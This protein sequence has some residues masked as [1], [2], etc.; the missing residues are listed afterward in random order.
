MRASC[1]LSLLASASLGCDRLIN[2]CLTA[3]QD[4]LDPRRLGIQ[5][6]G[7][8]DEDIADIICILLPYSEAARAELRE[9][10]LLN[11]KHMVET[12]AAHPNLQAP[13]GISHMPH[14]VGEHCIVLRLSAQYKDP[15]LGFAFGRNP[16]KCDVYFANDPFRRLS[17]IHFRIYLNE[18]GVLMLEDL[19]MNGTVVDGTMLKSKEGKA[20]RPG[21]K[22]QPRRRTLNPGSQ[23]KILMVQRD[24]D[25]NF[26]VQ[27]PRREGNYEEAYRKN[28][29]RYMQNLQALRTEALAGDVGKTITPGPGGHVRRHGTTVMHER[30]NQEKVDLFPVNETRRSTPH[31]KRRLGLPGDPTEEGLGRPPSLREW[32]GSGRYNL[33]SR[34]GR[35]AFAT[36]YKVT[37]KFDGRPY[38]AKEIE[39]RKFMKDGVL[40]QKV[41]NEMKIMQRAKHASLQMRTPL[42]ESTNADTISPTSSNTLSI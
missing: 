17:N 24:D 30:A 7:F 31:A 9:M 36:V 33:V 35:G 11:S 23:I 32:D 2:F 13:E 22:K 40:D 41:E 5:N 4:V 16:T 14:L 25:L 6:S 12:D 3:T 34:I 37:A 38:A 27:I 18:Y 28:Q 15:L 21:D 20:A 19:S 10:A 29:V 26:I 39:K 8:S 1:P 42:R